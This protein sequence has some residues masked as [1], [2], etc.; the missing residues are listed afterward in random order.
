M[1]F[2]RPSATRGKVKKAADKYR[3]RRVRGEIFD[4]TVRGS[5]DSTR[6]LAV[7]AEEKEKREPKSKDE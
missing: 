4:E 7:K 3:S 2:F 1:R 6:G 5:S